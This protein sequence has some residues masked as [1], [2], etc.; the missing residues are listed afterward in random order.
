MPE[1]AFDNAHFEVLFDHSPADRIVKYAKDIEA[2]MLV[3]ATRNK[4][5]IAEFFTSSFADRVLKFSPCDVL[6]LRPEKK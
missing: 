2:H 5:G 3:V 6:V 4:Q 1:R